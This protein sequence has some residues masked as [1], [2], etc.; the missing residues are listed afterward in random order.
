MVV[1]Y[2]RLDAFDF[3]L[4]LFILNALLALLLLVVSVAEPKASFKAVVARVVALHSQ[5]TSLVVLDI[6]QTASHMCILN[7]N[8]VHFVVWEIAVVV[9]LGQLVNS[10]IDRT[11]EL[12]YYLGLYCLQVLIVVGF[13]LEV[14]VD[15]GFFGRHG[16]VGLIEDY[17]MQT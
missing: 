10:M 9:G 6:V 2:L 4:D 12:V 11:I 17:Y 13:V 14:Q 16:I 15:L 3:G 1:S 5:L 8:L 7:F